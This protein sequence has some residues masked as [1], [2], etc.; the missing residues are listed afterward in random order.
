MIR[1][2]TLRAISQNLDNNLPFQLLLDGLPPLLT[3]SSTTKVSLCL[4]SPWAFIIG[5]WLACQR[6]PRGERSSWRRWPHSWRWFPSS[7]HP[8]ARAGTAWAAQG[9]PASWCSSAALRKPPPLSHWL[10]RCDTHQTERVSV[11]GNFL[12]DTLFPSPQAPPPTPTSPFL[13][14]YDCLSFFK[15]LDKKAT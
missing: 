5:R 3:P 12:L 6:W 14:L 7:P 10:G 8:G 9:S 1:P 13:P 4:Q 15:A 11:V 2:L